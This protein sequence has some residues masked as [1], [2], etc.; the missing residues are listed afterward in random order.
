[1]SIFSGYNAAENFMGGTSYTVSPLETLKL[2]AAASIFG[3]PKYYIDGIKSTKTVYS[4]YSILNALIK[5]KEVKN[6]A[7]LFEKVVDVALNFDFKATLDFALEL[8]TTY[9]MRL[10]P[11]VIYIRATLHPSRAEFNASMPGY[12]KS[13]GKSIALRPDDLTNQFE[14]YLSINESKSNLPSIVKRTW[15]EKLETYSSYQINKYKGKSLI[16]LVR[17][18]HANSDTIN[19]LMSTGKIKIKETEQTWES[20]KS[21]GKNWTEII[22]IIKI[23][24]MALL[25]N[26]RGIFTEISDVNQLKI[27]LNEL[28]SG[29]LTGKQ[30]PF[31]YWSAYKAIDKSF[32][33]N[34]KM[35]ILD[36]LEECM[37][38]SIENIPKLKGKTACLS[39]NSGSAWGSFNSEYGSVTVAEIGNLSS[40]ITVMSSEQ[41]EVGVFGDNLAMQPISKKNGLF[42]QLKAITELGKKQGQAT[43]N[44]IWIFFDNA[45]KNKTHYDTLFIYSDMQ[46]GHGDLYGHS[47]KILKSEYV[48]EYKGGTYIDVLK[49]ADTYRKLVNPKLN[50]FTVQTGGYNNNLIPEYLYRGAIL[51]GWTGKESLF[52][53][54][55]IEI[56]NEI[57]NNK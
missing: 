51:S 52:A 28:K 25:R 14:Y 38:I 12:M 49:M 22:S 21:T 6:S 56:W 1:M 26:L 46:A 35:I 41:G 15:S 53:S 39:D 13:I 44:G 10:N 31:R 50:L 19:E 3:E 17:I 32:N 11:S 8:R 36:A 18:S 48:H 2:V 27:L 4:D 37:D 5:E 9:M 57:E 23:P 16:D 7:D 43:E 54:S 33:V 40:L 55:N 30:F 20:L 29:V 34:N 42:T 47:E 45:I 24:H